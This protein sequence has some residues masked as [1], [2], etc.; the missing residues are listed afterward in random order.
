ML[1]TLKGI[2]RAKPR[3]L[4]LLDCLPSKCKFQILTYRVI[5]KCPSKFKI[6]IL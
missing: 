2:V 5:S 1:F 6:E 3:F 4:K